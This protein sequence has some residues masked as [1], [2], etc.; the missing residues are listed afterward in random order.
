MKK[1]YYLHIIFGLF[2]MTTWFMSETITIETKILISVIIL[3]FVALTLF[4]EKLYIL[5]KYW[6]E[7]ISVA[8]LTSVFIFFKYIFPNLFIPAIII[9]LTCILIAILM[10]FKYGQNLVYKSKELLTNVVI[11]TL[12]RLN[13][14]KSNC[15]SIANNKMIFTGTTAPIGTDGSHIDL[16]NIL[17]IGITYEISCFAKSIQNTSGE[18][19]LWC[20]DDTGAEAHGVT[21]SSPYKTPSLR[22]DIIKINF[23]A[24]YNKNIRV[25]LQYK[26]GLGQIE[27]SDMKIFKLKI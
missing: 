20:H 22:G 17:E 9:I 27:I 24:D 7:I 14:W 23:R 19:Q 18:F 2:G 6:Q 25:H 15:A 4:K 21:E 1:E 10:I 11:D 12:W 26:P 5:R 3:L 8:L 16:N 13:H